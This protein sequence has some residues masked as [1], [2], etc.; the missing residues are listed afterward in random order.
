MRSSEESSETT[1]SITYQ[2]NEVEV[3]K[4]KFTDINKQF[5]TIKE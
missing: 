3:W 1:S 2:K 4:K 5:Y